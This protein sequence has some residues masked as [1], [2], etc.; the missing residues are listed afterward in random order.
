MATTP[1]TLFS[2]GH[3]NVAVER[4]IAL[5]EQHTI[6]AL[7]DVRSAP[8]SRYNPQFNRETLAESLRAGGIAYRF[9]GDTLGGK[10]VNSALRTE[11]GA[12]VD[13]ARVAASPGFQRGLAQLI[14]LAERA[15]TAFMCG[16]ADYH[17]C[18]RHR[19]ITPALIER[20]V[21]VWHILP[22]GGLERGVIEPQQM[23]MF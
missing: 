8:Y 9:M 16:E 12:V 3:S 2:I 21:I 4:L 17:G 23:R 1:T 19:L 10:P 18:H 7:C 14:D 15:P 13:Y 20:G 22:D 6:Q 5:L 11:D